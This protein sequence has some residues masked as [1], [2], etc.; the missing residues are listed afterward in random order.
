MYNGE[1]SG[2]LDYLS[3]AKYSS[4]R[5]RPEAVDSRIGTAFLRKHEDL[6]D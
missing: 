4:S 2:R 1:R 3:V 5:V 6:I